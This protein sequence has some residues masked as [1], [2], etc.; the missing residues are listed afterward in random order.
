MMAQLH[1]E[2]PIHQRIAMIA[3][4]LAKVLDRGP[5]MSVE[6]TG[7]ASTDLG[8]YVIKRPY[9]DERVAHELDDIARELEI[10][11]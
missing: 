8:L 4:A 6:A 1:P 3:E 5:E 11:L 9:S 2:M 10:L 7:S